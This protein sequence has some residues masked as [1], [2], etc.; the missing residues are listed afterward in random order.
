MGSLT[1]F[2]E[3]V[4]E[5]VCMVWWQQMGAHMAEAE[6]TLT[7]REDSGRCSGVGLN[8]MA[9]GSLEVPGSS[10]ENRWGC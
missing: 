3:R 10:G 4:Q 9:V 5:Q 2:K 1:Q 7:T 8:S 6:R